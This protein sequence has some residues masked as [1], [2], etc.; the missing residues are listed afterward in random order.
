MKKFKVLK[1]LRLIGIIILF[2]IPIQNLFSQTNQ[3]ANYINSVFYYNRLSVVRNG[4]DRIILRDMDNTVKDSSSVSSLVLDFNFYSRDPDDDLIMPMMAGFATKNKWIKKTLGFYCLAYSTNLVNFAPLDS[5]DTDWWTNTMH[6]YGTSDEEKKKLRYWAATA[7]MH[8]D[9][10]VFTLQGDV[11][12]SKNTFTYFS[13]SFI[14]SIKTHIGIGLSKFTLADSIYASGNKT[15]EIRL[16][17]KILPDMLDIRTSAFK[18]ANI[19]FRYVNI[20]KAKYVPNISFAL[21][22]IIPDKYVKTIPVDVEVFFETRGQTPVEAFN[23][24]DFDVRLLFYLLKNP[25]GQAQSTLKSAVYLGLSYKS[26]EDGYSRTISE[27]G[28][29]YNGQHG[30]GGEFGWCLR[31]MGMQKYGYLESNFIKI[32]AYYNYSQYFE[33]YPGNVWGTKVRI[34]F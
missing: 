3:T 9:F 27:S 12:Y 2:L 13:K 20:I 22:Q 28:L 6:W 16:G 34:L 4:Y 26:P 29:V 17:K 8:L 25:G 11:T 33:R 7:G 15:T 1:D 24:K 18:F 23:L 31:L 32:C 5:N 21:N 19:G 10:R 30:F 14:P